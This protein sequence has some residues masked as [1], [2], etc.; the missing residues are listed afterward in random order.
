M[1]IQGGVF[2]AT[3]SK[4]SQALVSCILMPMIPRDEAKKK[5]AADGTVV[6]DKDN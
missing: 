5:A 2:T 1:N 3:R 4:G 6:R